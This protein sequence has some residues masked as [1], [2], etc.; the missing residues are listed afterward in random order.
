MSHRH[1]SRRGAPTR[2]RYGRAFELHELG[3]AASRNHYGSRHTQQ[4]RARSHKNRIRHDGVD[5]QP[6]WAWYGD[7]GRDL[8]T[9]LTQLKDGTVS[10]ANGYWQLPSLTDPPASEGVPLILGTHS[11]DAG[12][13]P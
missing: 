4:S 2:A 7:D 12:R 5:W 3:A 6:V 9:Q 13:L 11:S 8:A 1:S 10:L